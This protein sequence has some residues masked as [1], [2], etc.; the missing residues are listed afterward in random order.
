VHNS[1]KHSRFKLLYI[2]MITLSLI[3]IFA[4]NV[5]ASSITNGGFETGDLSG[6]D[7]FIPAGGSIIATND[8][9][10]VEQFSMSPIEGNYFALIRTNSIANY[11]TALSQ[12]FYASAGSKICGWAFF[13]TKDSYLG[14]Y[15]DASLVVTKTGSAA[16]NIL[17]QESVSSVGDNGI[18][19]WKYWEYYF[20]AS[21]TYTIEAKVANI[22]DRYNNSYIGIDDV[23]LISPAPVLTVP[24]DI[25]AEA[26]GITTPVTLGE[27]TADGILPLTITNDAPTEFP[28]GTTVVTWT[29]VD[30]YGNS[31]SASQVVTIFDNT[32]PEITAGIEDGAEFTLNELATF[33]WSASDGQSGLAAVDCAY[34]TGTPLDTS[35][36]GEKTINITAVDNAG[37]TTEKVIKYYVRYSF[38]GLFSPVDQDDRIYQSGST[39]PFKFCLEDANGSCVKIAKA[40]ISYAPVDPA[41]Y[42]TAQINCN[43]EPT[44]FFRFDEANMQY[45][46]NFSTAGFAAG[47]YYIKITLDDGSENII[48]IILR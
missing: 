8:P 28:L 33:S 30:A 15:N 18:T 12:P 13:K 39:I 6:W 9:L 34:Q 4:G 45:I 36:V 44:D 17:F 16:D 11:Y 43:F 2:T 25:T 22:G 24:A 32:A 35:T 31:A 41:I 42:W 21:G 3:V 26:T 27:A 7:T 14:I 20:P 29:A 5:L 40:T 19:P 10:S 47:E 38:I 37:N 23:K 1:G 46:Y 48:R